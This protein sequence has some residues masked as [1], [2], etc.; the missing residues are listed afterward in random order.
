[1]DSSRDQW[2]DVAAIAKLTGWTPAYVRK[3]SS[4]DGWARAGTK[5]Q[6]YRA[7]DVTRSA[8]TTRDTRIRS[9]LLGKYV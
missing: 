7:R 8:S 1:M 3:R 9:H 2:L 4:L 6:K 5:P